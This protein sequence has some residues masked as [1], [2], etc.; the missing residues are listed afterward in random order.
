MNTKI[1]KL[2]NRLIKYK[3]LVD[4]KTIVKISR[5][6]PI[7]EILTLFYTFH[8]KF[9]LF[10]RSKNTLNINYF[11]VNINLTFYINII[12][13]LKYTFLPLFNFCVDYFLYQIEKIFFLINNF[14]SLL[15]TLRLNIYAELDKKLTLYTTSTLFLNASWLEREILDFSEIKIIK[16]K[17]TRR[18]LL[19]Y[20]QIR[21]YPGKV[22]IYDFT[23]NHFLNDLYTI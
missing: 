19:D 14:S 21:Q 10:L 16:L 8:P 7:L 17:D 11:D 1:N 5:I 12:L 3:V 4:N 2:D 20:L 9:F 18:L 22:K 15:S 23:Y 6:P 13:H